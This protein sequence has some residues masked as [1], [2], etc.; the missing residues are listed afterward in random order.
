VAPQALA[1]VL[2]AKLPV[3]AMLE[4]VSV[5]VPELVNV[6]DLAVLVVFRI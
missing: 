4:M 2:T 3:A 6:T 5:P 1:P